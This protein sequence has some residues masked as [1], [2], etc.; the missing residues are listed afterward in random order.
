MGETARMAGVTERTLYALMRRHG[1]RKEDYRSGSQEG[2]A[3]GTDAAPAQGVAG[4]RS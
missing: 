1:L 4:P 3:P 2:A